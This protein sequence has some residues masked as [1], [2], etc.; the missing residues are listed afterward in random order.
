[1]GKK[2]S[3]KA[4]RG[5]RAEDSLENIA[6]KK[7]AE[8]AMDDGVDWRSYVEDTRSKYITRYVTLAQ[9]NTANHSFLE[10]ELNN[11]MNVA[12]QAELQRAHGAVLDMAKWLWS[13]GGQFLDLRGHAQE[14]LQL[15]TQAVDAARLL[16]DK[17]QE[18]SLLG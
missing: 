14:G 2:K 17:R 3:H 15:L 11:M 1:V 13:S 6:A 16:E 12:Q 18:G 10:E 5:S 4:N 7:S 9:Q 8:W